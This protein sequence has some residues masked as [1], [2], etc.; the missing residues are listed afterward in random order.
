MVSQQQEQ[1][2]I[3]ET[4]EEFL[5]DRPYPVGFSILVR[6]YEEDGNH[7]INHKGEKS[8]ILKPD[9]FKEREKYK[10]QMG[11]VI[12]IGP[13][14]Y[15]LDKVEK[16]RCRVGDNIMFDRYTSKPF[17]YN[18]VPFAFC[19]DDQVIGGIPDPSKVKYI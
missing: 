2:A 4:S 14:A 8:M 9:D 5:R 1:N 15:P 7:L 6:I 11:K 18:G 10:H 3:D 17:L 12:G 13:E 16:P 19:P